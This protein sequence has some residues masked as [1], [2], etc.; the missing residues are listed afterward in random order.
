MSGAGGTA[1]SPDLRDPG[2]QFGDAELSAYGE[3]ELQTLERVL[4]EHR[5]EALASVHE[6]ISRKI[7]RWPEGSESPRA[8]LD[9]YYT[10]LRARLE[11]NMRMGRRKADKYS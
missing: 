10:Q 1:A 2:L 6:A 8:F 11:T 9:A 4:R 5:P 3:Y 7:G